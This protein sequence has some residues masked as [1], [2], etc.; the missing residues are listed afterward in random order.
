M[1]I[2]GIIPARGG[3]KGLPGKNVRP[4]GGKPMLAWSIDAAKAS[5]RL[6]RTVVSTE[7]AAIARIAR[8]RGGD[9]PF[10]RPAAL[11]RDESGTIEVLQHAVRWLE[12]E[13]KIK[14]DLIVLLQPTSPLRLARDIDDTVNLVLKTGADSAQTVAED[15]AHPWHRFRLV[16]GRLKPMHPEAEKFS[17]R[18]AAPPLYRPTGSVYV[19]RY[20][21]LMKQNAVHGKHHRGVVRDFESSIDI[22]DK[23]D[24]ELARLILSERTRRGTK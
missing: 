4:L 24:L 20:N 2:F 12:S 11:S 14:P 15:R 13:E 7:D 21:V 16:G 8:R 1:Y 5:R 19:M 18:Q 23:W 3:S 17:R 9:V 22:D 6:T 10:K